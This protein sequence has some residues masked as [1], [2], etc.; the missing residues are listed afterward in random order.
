MHPMTRYVR[1]RLS[2]EGSVRRAAKMQ[3]YM[4]TSQP[5]HGVQRPAQKAILREVKKQ[6]T[7]PSFEEY[8]QV[9]TE[10]WSGRCREEMYLAL[11]VAEA[12]PRFRVSKVFPFFTVL[13]QTAPHWD[14][15]DRICSGLLSPLLRED[16]S[17][18]RQVFTW[19]GSDSFW[20]RRAS[21]LVHLRQ[22]DQTNVRLLERTILKLAPDP[23]FFVRKAI[24]WVLR[25]YAETNPRWVRQFVREHEEEL[26]PLSKREALKHLE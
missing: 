20:L 22:K 12:H 14:T 26:A 24:G 13:L 1:A 23:E 18:E 19:S 25:E 11:D 16:R 8:K 10:L 15:V 17:Y 6:F 21:L 3:A 4:K 9:I 2:E 7:I 5:F